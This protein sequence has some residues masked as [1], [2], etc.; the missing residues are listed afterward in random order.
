MSSRKMKNGKIEIT[1]LPELDRYGFFQ[2]TGEKGPSGR[3]VMGFLFGVDA[4]ELENALK[5]LKNTKNG[6]I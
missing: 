6:G 3:P 1:Y 4:S 2:D 5:K